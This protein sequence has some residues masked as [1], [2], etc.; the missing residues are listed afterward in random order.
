M[1]SLQTTDPSNQAPSSRFAAMGPPKFLN[2][3]HI[4]ASVSF[5][6]AARGADAAP[7]KK[8]STPTTSDRRMPVTVA[9]GP[10]G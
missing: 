3:L 5:S 1:G 6:F 7:S 2:R 8:Q 9:R 10:R 4:S